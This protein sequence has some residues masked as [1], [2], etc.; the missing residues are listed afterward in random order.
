[1]RPGLGLLAPFDA[2]RTRVNDHGARAQSWPPLGPDVLDHAIQDR[3]CLGLAAQGARES[4]DPLPVRDSIND[5]LGLIDA[6][7]ACPCNLLIDLYNI[8]TALALEEGDEGTHGPCLAGSLDKCN[9][10]AA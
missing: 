3:L 9:R 8:I 1:M 5:R 2:R 10:S 4:N 6:L 7:H